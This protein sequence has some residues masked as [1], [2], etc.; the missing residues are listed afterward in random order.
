MHN[1]LLGDSICMDI[2]KTADKMKGISAD[3]LKECPGFPRHKIVDMRNALAHFCWEE[4]TGES[5][6]LE[7]D[8]GKV[9]DFVHNTLFPL[10]EYLTSVNL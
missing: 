5:N 9:W 6:E 8:C 4:V 7:I 10:G 3:Y 1:E 2:I